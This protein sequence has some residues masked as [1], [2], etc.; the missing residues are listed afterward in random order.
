MDLN[1]YLS[2][3]LYLTEFKQFIVVYYKREFLLSFEFVLLLV[4]PFFRRRIKIW[5][6]Y[7]NGET[8]SFFCIF[9]V[10]FSYYMHETVDFILIGIANRI[11]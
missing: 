1:Y 7:L 3:V 4:V 6:R 11:I 5:S 2:S 8:C 9:M 10:F